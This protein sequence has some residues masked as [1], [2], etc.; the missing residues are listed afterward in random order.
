MALEI[1]KD[2]LGFD[3]PVND[4]FVVKILYAE[5]YFHDEESSHTLVHPF[6]VSDVGK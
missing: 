1:D 4:I 6:K 3:V 5:E 2:I